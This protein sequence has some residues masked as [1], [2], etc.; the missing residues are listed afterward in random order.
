MKSNNFNQSIFHFL[1]KCHAF[2]LI[3]FA[4]NSRNHEFNMKQRFL[5]LATH[6]KFVRVTYKSVQSKMFSLSKKKNYLEN[7]INRSS[8]VP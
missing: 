5:F 2:Q 1:S 6:D 3:R 7:P 8:I 4:Y